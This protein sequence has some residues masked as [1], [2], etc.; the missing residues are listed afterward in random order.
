[1]D[2]GLH[3]PGPLFLFLSVPFPSPCSHQTSALQLQHSNAGRLTPE[4]PQHSC[5]QG[6]SEAKGQEEVS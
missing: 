5:S 4:L 3:L 1:M 2:Q 6:Q